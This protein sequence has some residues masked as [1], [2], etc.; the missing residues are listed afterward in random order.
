MNIQVK[1][2]NRAGKVMITFCVIV[3]VASGL[4]L[5]QDQVVKRQG[6]VGKWI[7]SK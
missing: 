5:V 2:L 4:F 6:L 1:P 3:S 7:Q